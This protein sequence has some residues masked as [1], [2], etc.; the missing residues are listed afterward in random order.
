MLG[1]DFIKYFGD[2]FEIL[3]LDRNNGNITDMESMDAFIKNNK[4][5]AIVNFAAYTNVEDAEDS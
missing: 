5:D 4:P 2:R 3:P 1:T